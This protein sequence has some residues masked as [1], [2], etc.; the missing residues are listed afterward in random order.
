MSAVPKGQSLEWTLHSQAWEIL[1]Q[2]FGDM[3]QQSFLGHLS[4]QATPPHVPSSSSRTA[5]AALT[6][7]NS[8]PRPRNA[9]CSLGPFR[10]P[11]QTEENSK[12]CLT[13]SLEVSPHSVPSEHLA[14]HS[15]RKGMTLE[16]CKAHERH[17]AFLFLRPKL[18][19]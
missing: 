11:S 8:R 14:S 3:K 5:G 10:A 4:I 2:H 12:P 7:N 17:K 15:L 9:L 18:S 16:N 6:P 19:Y 1:L 13:D